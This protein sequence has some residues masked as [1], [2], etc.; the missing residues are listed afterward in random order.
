MRCT[1]FPL[2]FI[3]KISIRLIQKWKKYFFFSH[4]LV[5]HDT[6]IVCMWASECCY[7]FAISKPYPSHR[8]CNLSFCDHRSTV[9]ANLACM[10]NSLLNSLWLSEGIVMYQY[11]VK[12]AIWKGM[13]FSSAS[14]AA[15]IVHY[16]W[17]AA[18]IL[19]LSNYEE[20]WLLLAYYW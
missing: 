1:F 16:R 9:A 20:E 13:I 15:W 14:R 3:K 18:K 5:V 17:R 7:Y 19:P 8:Q 12:P 2:F 11:T 10:S 6:H 4:V